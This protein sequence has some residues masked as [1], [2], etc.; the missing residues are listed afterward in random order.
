VQDC[1]ETLF[2]SRLRRDELGLLIPFVNGI[3]ELLKQV[4]RK[5]TSCRIQEIFS[6]W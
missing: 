5:K 4:R 3:R 2:E 6:E 1:G